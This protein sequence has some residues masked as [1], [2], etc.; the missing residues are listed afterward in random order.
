[1]GQ[2]GTV[3]DEGKTIGFINQKKKKKKHMT[4]FFLSSLCAHKQTKIIIKL[5]ITCAL[6]CIVSVC[7]QL[8]HSAIFS[9]VPGCKKSK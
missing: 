8:P 9:L 4:F 2:C 3:V 1:M 6:Y 7:G 5:S